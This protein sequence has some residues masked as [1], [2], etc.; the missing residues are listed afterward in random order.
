MKFLSNEFY[1]FHF[2]FFFIGDLFDFPVHV[3]AMLRGAAVERGRR[4]VALFFAGRSDPQ[5]KLNRLFRTKNRRKTSSQDE[6]RDRKT[7]R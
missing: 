2:D 4:G 1:F 6:S 7:I 3:H 5:R